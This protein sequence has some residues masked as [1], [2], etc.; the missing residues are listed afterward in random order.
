MDKYNDSTPLKRVKSEV[1]HLHSSETEPVSPLLIKQSWESFMN[2]KKKTKYIILCVNEMES[3][4][5]NIVAM[6]PLRFNYYKSEWK[7]FNDGTDDILI[8]GFQPTNRIAGH[9]ILFLASFYNNDI[10]LSQFSVFI[11]LLQSFIHSLTIV[12]PFYPVGTMER[13][14]V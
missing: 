12:L 11:A 14:V 8:G 7:K 9:N 3:L 13:V 1:I 5:E 2:S 4:A 6:Y 10:T